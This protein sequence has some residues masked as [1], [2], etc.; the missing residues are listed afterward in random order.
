MLTLVIPAF[1]EIDSL[2]DEFNSD[3]EKHSNDCQIYY[4][5]DDYAARKVSFMFQ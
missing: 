2:V 4:V 3:P 1:L 5:R